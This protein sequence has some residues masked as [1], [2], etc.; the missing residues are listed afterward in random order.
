MAAL[1][2]QTADAGD[3][4]APPFGLTPQMIICLNVINELTAAT[5]VPP[6]YA[7]IA[8]ELDLTSRSQIHRLVCSLEERGWISRLHGRGRS[9]TILQQ[10]PALSEPVF[11]LAED[12]AG[13]E[14]LAQLP[15]P[16]KG[17]KIWDPADACPA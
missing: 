12:T 16:P 4:A 15:P 13:P 17:W 8:A 3:D 10:V 6:S 5:G 1:A 9:I 11:V 7:E 14:L 2:P